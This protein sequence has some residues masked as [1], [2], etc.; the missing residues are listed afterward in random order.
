[1]DDGWKWLAV[2]AY[3]SVG[4]FHSPDPL[5]NSWRNFFQH[6]LSFQFHHQSVIHFRKCFVGHLSQYF[7]GF[8][9][10][11]HLYF[12]CSRDAILPRAL[13]CMLKDQ[14]IFLQ[15]H[16]SRI[17]CHICLPINTEALHSPKEN[18]TIMVIYKPWK[19]REKRDL[20][21][22]THSELTHGSSKIFIQYS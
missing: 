7:I 8:F 14:P 21:A 17:L 13:G 9:W 5:N 3:Q 12:F 2:H 11:S 15:F 6:Q 1:M 20:C 19:W 18:L 16:M 4:V 22:V 10:S